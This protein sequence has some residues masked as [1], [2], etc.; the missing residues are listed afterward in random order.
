MAQLKTLVHEAVPGFMKGGN[1]NA[2]NLVNN[3]IPILKEKGVGFSESRSYKV[4]STVNVVGTY[5]GI[6]AQL[7]QKCAYA[8]YVQC[9]SHA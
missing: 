8:T 3:M 9:L 4:D 2:E 1:K 5:P 7:L 6:Q